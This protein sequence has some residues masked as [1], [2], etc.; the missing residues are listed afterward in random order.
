VRKALVIG[1]AGQIGSE[2]TL[3]LSDLLGSENVIASDIRALSSEISSEV[4]TEI[5][6]VLKPKQISEVIARHEVNEVYHLAAA[7]SA[8]AEKK[9]LFSW[10]LNMNGLLNV[11]ECCKSAGISKIFWP[12][13]VAVFGPDSPSNPAPQLTIMNPTSIYGISKLAGE[14]FCEYYCDK[15]KLDIRSLRFPGIL[16]YKTDPGG[17]TT[18]Y[19][20]WAMKHAAEEKPYISFLKAESVLP[21]MHMSDAVSAI[22]NLMEADKKHITVRSSYNV[23]S[24]SFSGRDLENAI[25]EVQPNFKMLYEPD[26]RQAIADSWPD[27]MDDSVAQSEWGWKPKYDFKSTVC[28]IIAGFKKKA[29]LVTN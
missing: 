23:S 14:R 18:D 8:T 10:D 11:L 24:Y 6:D 4:T 7:L 9:P 17:G 3:A 12:S 13:S 15:H 25:R 1:S 27:S 19:A 22:L 29:L 5:L 28:D 21:M 20:L 2:L 16:S 26:F